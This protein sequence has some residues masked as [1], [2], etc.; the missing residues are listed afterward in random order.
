MLSLRRIK[1]VKA[2]NLPVEQPTRSSFSSISNPPWHSALTISAA[3]LALA[4][5]VIE[6]DF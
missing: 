2:G 5:D 4:D 6:Q 3:L 1:V